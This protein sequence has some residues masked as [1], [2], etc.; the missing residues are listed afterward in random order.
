M[1][2]PNMGGPVMQVYCHFHDQLLDSWVDVEHW[3]NQGRCLDELS[4][5]HTVRY[6]YYMAT[7]GYKLDGYSMLHNGPHRTL[8]ERV[9]DFVIPYRFMVALIPNTL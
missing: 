9:K 3:D 2:L 1:A 7:S 6:N 4:D 8:K 5:K